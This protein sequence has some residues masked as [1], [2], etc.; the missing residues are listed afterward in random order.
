MKKFFHR[1]ENVAF[2]CVALICCAGVATASIKGGKIPLHDGDVLVDSRNI[3]AEPAENNA[4]EDEN[5]FESK[6]AKLEL[7][8]T[9]LIAKYDETIKNSENKAEKNNAV[10]QK[11][12]LTGYMEQEI[13]IE[14]IIQSKNL[15]PSMALITDSSITIT[16]DEQDLQQNTAAKI[17][18]IVMEETGRTADKII[19]QS[20]Y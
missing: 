3:A 8:R 19:I 6:K 13:A 20:N 14:G 12:R 15:P 9:N 16:V 2:L 11:Q 1:K 10:K 4:D 18:S 7:E 5:T 17:C